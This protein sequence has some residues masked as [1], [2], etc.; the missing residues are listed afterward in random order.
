MLEHPYY[1]TSPET[2]REWEQSQADKFDECKVRISDNG[3]LVMT[4]EVALPSK[5]ESLLHHEEERYSKFGSHANANEAASAA[6]DG[7]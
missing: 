2:I 1:N 4:A 6:N 3:R 7:I 5:F